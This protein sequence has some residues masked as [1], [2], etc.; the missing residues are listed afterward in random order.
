VPILI[1]ELISLVGADGMLAPEE[2]R[3]RARNYWDSTPLEAR[4]LVRP[5]TTEQLSGVMR[6]CNECD[7]PVVVHG[8]LTGVCD[9]DRATATDIVVSLERMTAIEDIDPI[10]RTVTVQAGCTLQNLQNAAEQVGLLFPLDLG[11]RGS[12]T[13][14]GNVATNAGGTAVIRFGMM[15]A[16]VLGLEAVLVDG[17]VISSMN[18]MLKNNTGY[19]LK[20]LF[21]GSE[22]TLGIVTRVV[23][24]LKERSVGENTV[25][26]ALDEGKHLPRLLKLM[27][28]RLGGTL[29][30]FEAMWGDYF[31]AVTA[32]GWHRAPMN[33]DHAFYV[34]IEAQGSDPE[35]DTHRF[36]A[37]IEQAY[38]S[39]LIVDAVVPKS[40]AERD[41][42]WSIRENFEALREYQPLF[43]YDVSLPLRD[44]LDYVAEVTATLKRLWPAC[45]FFALGHI[46][47]G[48]LHF[49]VAP[50]EPSGDPLALHAKCDEAVYRPLQRIGGAVSAEHGIGLE[51]KA[52]MSVTR[53]AAE[54]ELMRRIKQALDPQELLNRGKVID[55]GLGRA[56]Q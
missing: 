18:R 13:V 30:A 37:V 3:L 39:G 35:N 21:I 12:C 27:D 23:L 48:N 47:D 54:I 51:K 31:R 52:W 29:S 19:D 14:G 40:Q 44:M 7:Q 22:G 33:R 2:L 56:C 20:Q 1:E 32:T 42:I 17:T 49:F 36:N 46:G 5:K 25:L 11:A 4:A 53:S 43:L 28:Q 38:E 8:G 24:T 41:Q 34:I 45:Q 10:G 26:V 55:V 6:L 9:A 16:L 15:R 50:Q